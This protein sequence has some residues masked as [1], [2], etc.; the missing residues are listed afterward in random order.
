VK[1]IH[2]HKLAREI[3]ATSMANSL[4]NRMGPTFIKSQMNKTAASS[5]QI[6]KAYIIV[7]DA[8]DLRA[9]WDQIEALDNKVPAEVQLKAMREIAL[10]AE[11]AIAWFL[12]RLGSDLHIGREIV[13]YGQS[14]TML[15]ENLSKIVTPNLKESI[16]LRTQIGMRDGLP[17]DLAR[18]IALMPVLSSAC[19]IIRI[20]L[21]QKTDT[22]DTAHAYFQVGEQ[23]HMDWLRQQARF[24]PSDDH[25]AAEAT[26]GLVDQL[27]GAQ[28]FL[29]VRILRD[30]KCTPDKDKTLAETWL[31]SHAHQVKQL[32]P[33]FADLRRAGTIDLP[34]LIIAEQK[35]RNLAGG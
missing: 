19:D 24:L 33:L 16:D 32:E 27:F 7:R 26:R 31:E 17:A 25:W 21:E 12:T 10:L 22:L 28:A 14:V 34:M 35:L 18:Q 2:R 9:L 23:F 11:H 6:A 29:T 13:N 15:R 5:D 1:E 20:S 3:V 4:I 8:F 30:T